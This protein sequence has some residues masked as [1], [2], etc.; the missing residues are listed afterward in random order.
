MGYSKLNRK[1]TEMYKKDEESVWD[2]SRI[3]AFEELKQAVTKAPAL[4]PI[5]YTSDCS[6]ILAV[7]TSLHTVGMV[8]IQLGDRQAKACTLWFNSSDGGRGQIQ[9]TQAGIT[10][11]V[12]S[13]VGFSNLSCR[14]QEI[15]G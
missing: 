14:S 4:Q 5:N 15:D 7:D 10:W 6:V 8:L 9:S 1:L 3:Q 11:I 2:E 13:I 12:S